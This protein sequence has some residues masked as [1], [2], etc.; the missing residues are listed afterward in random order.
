MS[1]FSTPIVFKVFGE[2]LRLSVR[3]NDLCVVEHQVSVEDFQTIL[4]CSSESWIGQGSV[5][6]KK[7]GSKVLIRICQ[8]SQN[9]VYSIPSRAFSELSNE[10]LFRG[11]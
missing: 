4:R 9:F 10:F 8:N 11:N 5:W 6:A 3:I 2:S 1:H 7:K